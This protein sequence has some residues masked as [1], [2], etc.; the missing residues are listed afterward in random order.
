MKRKNNKHQGNPENH[1][2][3]LLKPTKL[4]NLKEMDFF[5]IDI[6]YQR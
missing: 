5:L 6:T 2:D 1:K 3:I 4:E